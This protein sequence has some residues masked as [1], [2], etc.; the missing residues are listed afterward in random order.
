MKKKSIL[1]NRNFNAI[2]T[3]L[4]AAGLILGITEKSSIIQA[5]SVKEEKTFLTQNFLTPPKTARPG[6]YWYFMDGNISKEGMTRDL[7]AM[8]AAGIGYL[9]YLEVNVGVPRGK[10]DF[11]S[12]EWIDLFKHAVRECER[13]GIQITLGVGPG[14]TGSGGPWVKG[15]Q[16]MQHLVHHSI[17]VTGTEESEL[18]RFVLPSPHPMPPFFGTGNFTPQ[19]YKEWETYYQD[20]AVL[21]FPTPKEGSITDIEEKALYYR[22]PYSSQPGVKPYLS[23][24]DRLA[25]TPSGAAVSP[26]QMIDLTD[27]LSPVGILGWEVPP[28]N[29]TLMRIGC[30]NNGAVTR[31]A[32]L[33][34]VGMECDKFSQSA[35]QAHLNEFTDKLLEAIAPLDTNTFGGLKMLHM[36]SWEMGAQNW[37]QGFREEFK[38]RRGYDPLPYYPVYAGFIVQSRQTSERFL[39]D[40]RM[41]SQELIME[42]HVSAIKEYGRRFGLGLSIEPYDMNP[43]SDLE[44]A[45]L[46]DIPMCEFW[47]QGLGFN[48]SFSLMEGTSA[49]HLIG[50]PVVQAEAFTA[51]LDGWK[52]HPASMKN[53]TDWALAGGINR[54]FFHTFQHQSLPENL[55]PGMT[56]GPYGVHWDRNQTWWPL[57][58]A[59]HTYLARCQFLLQQGNHSADILYL[60]P[61]EAPFVFQAPQSALGGSDSF[62]PDRKGYNFDACPPS[63]LYQAQVKE[64]KIRFPGGASYS[65][66]VLPEYPLMT[67][68]LLSQI[69][70]LLQNGALVVGKAPKQA[71]GLENYPQCDAELSSL[72]LKIWGEKTEP[73]RHVGKGT[74]YTPSVPPENLYPPYEE[75]SLILSKQGIKPDFSAKSDQ[76]RYAHR[77]LN[78]GELYFLSNR[79][80]Q[81]VVTR[82]SFRTEKKGIPELWNPLTGEIRPLPE[83][84]R[85][86]DTVEIP[87]LWEPYQSFFIYFSQEGDSQ[88]LPPHNFPDKETILTL[89]NDWQLSFDPAW[90][91]PESIH[92]PTLTDWSLHSNPGIKYYSGTALY[93]KTF[94]LEELPPNTRWSLN[95]GN[96]KNIAKVSLNEK[97][98]GILWT[99]PWEIE[100]TSALQSGENKLEIQVINLWPNRLIGDEQLPDDGIQNGQWPEWLLQ[101]TP[102]PSKRLTFTTYKHYG[103]DSPLLESGLLG[104]VT[105]QKI[106]P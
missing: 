60:I 35:L 46:A 41:T 14:W 58:I 32:P 79:T 103:K 34:G 31:P 95:L 100:I 67:P 24:T 21:A 4:L 50:Q 57:S 104:P 13:L 7:E 40:L 88:S 15:E 74:L 80:N 52:Q 48:T 81:K 85:G 101:G 83:F 84:V 11:L 55:R 65:L 105:L 97:E 76:I 17:Q 53:Q 27:R 33:P 36:D 89:N 19:M 86:K 26:D 90:G 68:K 77:I 56:M 96:V 59:Y 49:A 72:I 69:H 18:Q 39:W 29:W 47:S 75:T 3:L 44:L 25:E 37:T 73:I 54:L 2:S 30:C 42:N 82:C 12:P 98:I 8:N 43:T 64:G 63:L 23:P 9:V 38:K 93:T 71:P 1:K 62:L 6:V 5:S 99:T 70:S 10:I 16:S 102:R 20:V 45:S 61:E 22:A 106:K 66:L 91:G 94:S 78:E 92:F 28:G 51:H 87:L